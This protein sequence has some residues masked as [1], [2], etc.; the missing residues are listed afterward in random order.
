MNFHEILRQL[1][2]ERFRNPAPVVTVLRFEGVITPRASRNSVSLAS[3]AAAIERVLAGAGRRR[4]L[5]RG[6]LAA[7]IDR[8]RHIE[9]RRASPDRTLRY[10]ATALYRRRAQIAAR[11]VLAGGPLR[12]RA[13]LGAAAGHP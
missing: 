7:R 2:I 11:P 13:A 6:N 4:G 3:H 5:G 1:P 8:G 10:R 9:F 12:R